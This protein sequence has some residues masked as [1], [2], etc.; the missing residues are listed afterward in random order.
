MKEQTNQRVDCIDME[1]NA[2]RNSDEHEY[3]IQQFLI[4]ELQCERKEIL[5][6]W[7]EI[8]NG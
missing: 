4:M 6:Q 2:L 3:S 5:E 8:D 1:I 7:Y